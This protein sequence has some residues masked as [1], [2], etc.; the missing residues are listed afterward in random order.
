ML[1]EKHR[2]QPVKKA[3]ASPQSRLQQFPRSFP[4]NGYSANTGRSDSPSDQTEESRI[5]M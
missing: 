1:P 5:G 2:V 4:R 3:S